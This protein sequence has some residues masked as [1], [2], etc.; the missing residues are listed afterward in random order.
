M[1]EAV[2]ELPVIDD[3][4]VIDD[5]WLKRQPLTSSSLISRGMQRHSKR[6]DLGMTA[7]VSS[8]PSSRVQQA[9]ENQEMGPNNKNLIQCLQVLSRHILFTLD[10]FGPA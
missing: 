8:M 5:Q 4:E 10:S 6:D 9:T 2:I 3:I 1:V 7:M